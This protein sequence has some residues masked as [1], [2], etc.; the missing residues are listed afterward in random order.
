MKILVFSIQYNFQIL[1]YQFQYTIWTILNTYHYQYAEKSSEVKLKI[2]NE[3]TL[4]INL[5]AWSGCPPCFFVCLLLLRR[6]VKKRP[7]GSKNAKITRCRR[8]RC[9]CLL[10]S[11]YD[12]Q[13]GRKNV[14]LFSIFK[15]L[16]RSF[17]K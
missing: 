2:G 7:I 4:A 3:Q 14:R 15:T 16:S 8:C 12:F 9:Y 5:N 10:K 13:N 17:K 11:K 6:M 1:K